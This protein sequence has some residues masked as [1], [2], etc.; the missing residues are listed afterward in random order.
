M[1]FH[2]PSYARDSSSMMRVASSSEMPNRSSAFSTR[3]AYIVSSPVG[4]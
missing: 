2:G 3:N 1:E 4:V